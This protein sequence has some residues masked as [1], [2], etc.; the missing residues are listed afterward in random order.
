MLYVFIFVCDCACVWSTRWGAMP[1]CRGLCCEPGAVSQACGNMSSFSPLSPTLSHSSH[2]VCLY[3]TP[4]DGRWHVVNTDTKQVTHTCVRVIRPW[5]KECMHVWI[6]VC[7]CVH[8]GTGFWFSRL[9][10]VVSCCSD[11]ICGWTVV[12]NIIKWICSAHRVKT[13]HCT[14]WENM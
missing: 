13:R 8:M 10:Y 14:H 11:H 2:P 7:M 3:F 4:V 9:N 1:Q 6:L 12:Q 5:E